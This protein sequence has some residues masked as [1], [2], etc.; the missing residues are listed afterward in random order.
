MAPTQAAIRGC[1]PWPKD[2][3]R[4]TF[5]VIWAIDAARKWLSGFRASY[6]DTIVGQADGQPGWLKPWFH[7]W[8]NLP[9]MALLRTWRYRACVKGGRWSPAPAGS[10]ARS[11]VGARPPRRCPP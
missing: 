7:F 5:G 2:A 4:I 11:A 8:I 3:L 10:A 9:L 6:M 1:T